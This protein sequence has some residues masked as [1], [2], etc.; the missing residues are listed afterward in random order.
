ML[1]VSRAAM[2]AWSHILF[3]ERLRIEPNEEGSWDYIDIC[4]FL[5]RWPLH[6]KKSLSMD[7]HV[8]GDLIRRSMSPR[9]I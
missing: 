3:N 1:P 6:K 7:A 5:F 8:L 4:W 9:T 2:D